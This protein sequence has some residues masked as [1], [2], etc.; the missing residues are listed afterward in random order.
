MCI[1]ICGNKNVV[2]SIVVLIL[3]IITL[4]I[5]LN[6]HKIYE[7]KNLYRHKNADSL[8]AHFSMIDTYNYFIFPKLILASPRMYTLTS[9]QSLYIPKHWWHWVK[10]IKKTFAINYWFINTVDCHPLVFNHTIDYDVSLL[11]NEIVQVWKSDEDDCSFAHIF[12]D[13]YNSGLD[14]R[15]VLTL[16]NYVVGDKNA[17]IKNKIADHV[18]FPNNSLFQHDENGYDYN[19]WVS[20]NKHDTGLHYDDE[21]GILTVISGQKEIILFPPS[22]SGY[23]YPYHMDYAWKNVN[24]AT[25]FKYN[26]FTYVGDVCG[27]SSGE[28]LYIT[29]NNDKRVLNNVSKLYNG[30]KNNLIWG[31]KKTNSN[32]GNN[33]NSDYRWEIYNYTLMEPVSITS[34]D[35]YKNQY[36]LG[37]EEHYYYKVDDGMPVQLPFWGYGKYKKNNRM[38]DESKI[39]VIDYYETFYANYD[40]YMIKMG[41]AEIKEKFKEKIFNKYSCYEICIFNKNP[42][43]IFVMYLGITNVEFLEF[44]ITNCYPNYVTEF[45]KTQINRG[46]YNINN[47]ITIVYDIRTQEIIR[48]G[49]YGVILW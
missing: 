28:L 6:I 25:N 47:E 2:L 35:V 39:F 11:N 12:K 23:L 31:F 26:S 4:I 24:N 1:A 43:Q 9:G 32:N 45:V 37:D 44:L 46:T 19:V 10:T 20:S 41:Y 18:T 21:D 14:N 22:D 34:F 16:G 48:S 13:F 42:T 5:S 15:Y 36:Q 40:D 38:H 7:S 30:L 8:Y 27:T 17:T 29:C 3:L 49:F 33:C